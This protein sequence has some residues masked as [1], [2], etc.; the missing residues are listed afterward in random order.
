M[1]NAIKSVPATQATPA[2][3]KGQ[4]AKTAAPVVR[5]AIPTG[6]AGCAANLTAVKAGAKPSNYYPQGDVSLKLHPLPP[7]AGARVQ[8]NHAALVAALVGTQGTLSVALANGATR[9][10]VRQLARAGL[11]VWQ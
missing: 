10:H 8:L 1:N 2:A 11:L 4:Q 5:P 9:R 7:T 3:K 6:F